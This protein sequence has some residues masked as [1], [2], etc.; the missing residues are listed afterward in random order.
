MMHSPGVTGTYTIDG[1]LTRCSKGRAWPSAG[2][3]SVVTIEVARLSESVEV[4]GRIS[5]VFAE[6]DRTAS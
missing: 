1:A 6:A 2:P 5:S 4:T 3:A